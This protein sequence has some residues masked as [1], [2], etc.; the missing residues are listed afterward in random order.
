MF[1]PAPERSLL[2]Y[3]P[4][5]LALSVFLLFALLLAAAVLLGMQFERQLLSSSGAVA[6][7]GGDP[8]AARLGW[9]ELVKVVGALLALAALGIVGFTTFQNYRSITQTFEHVKSL[10]RNVLQSIPT[11]V[12]TLDG[13]GSVT[14]LN[15]AAERLLDL[16]ASMVVGRSVEQVLQT[17]PQLASWVR[18][19]LTGDGLSRETDL[20]L[21]TGGGRRMVLRV[22][23]AELRDESGHAEGLVVLVRDVTELNRLELQLRRADKLAALGTLAAGVAHEVKNPLHALSLNL[24]LLVQE[25]EAP[26]PSKAELANYLGILRSE[27]ER[28]HRIVENFLRFSKPSIPEVKP[29][30]LNGLVE[31]VL[32]L[33]A[34]E[35]AGH[36]V[37]LQTDFDA[38]LD[39]IA[40]DEGQLAQVVLN[41]V[42]NALQ[43]MPQGG[44]LTVATRQGAAWVELMVTDTGDGIPQELIP[45][46]FDPYFTT[47]QGGSGLGLAIAHRIVE[48]HHGTIDVESKAG[49]GTTMLLRLPV[50]VTVGAARSG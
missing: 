10:M 5:R 39:A 29:L 38:G 43:A 27:I 22:S 26:Q 23:A 4:L 28:I 2:G 35:A 36:R 30:D 49:E 7:A 33:V 8:W 3:V 47:R 16:R 41:L 34:F 11:G 6:A 15:G 19:A 31:R 1:R 21:V 14:S 44:S 13:R 9:R 20:P 12:M 18:S 46:I 40:G 42:I 17:A 25:I 50:G 24:H 37:T 45:Q 32:S 48:G